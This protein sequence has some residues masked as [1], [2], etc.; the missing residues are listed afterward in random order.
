MQHARQGRQHVFQLVGVDVEAGHQ[1]HVLLAV[2]DAHVTVFLDHRDI[3][4]LQPA[5]GVE[6][7]VGGVLALPVALHHLWS[8]DAQLADRAER[9]FVALVVDDLALGRGHR[10]ADGAQ[11]DVLDRVDRGHRAGFG[12]AETF[13]YRAAGNLGP[14]LGSGQLQGHAA[15]QGDLQRGKVELLE[16]LVVAQGNEQG[17]EADEAA[18]L[19]ARQIL[20]HARQVARVGDQHVMVADQHHGHAMEGEGVDVIERQRRYHDFAAFVHVRRH[21]RPGLQ[22][23]GDQVAVGQHRALGHP[24]GA[25]GVLQHGELAASRIG[26]PDR[27]AAAL[28]QG[29]GELDGLRQ[30]VGRHHLLHVLDH[31]VDQQ[32]LERRQHVADFADDDRLDSGPGNDLLDQMRHV[33]QADQGFGAGVVELVLHFPRGIQRIGVDHHQ[34]GT[35]GAE[36]GD[37]VLQNVGQ[38]HGDAVARLQVGVLL[39]IGG[40]GTGQLI[41]L[42]VADG[43]A[44]VAEGRLVGET[45]A[46]LFQYR[47]NIRV[48]VGIDFGSNPNGILVLPKIFGHA[49]PLLSNS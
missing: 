3:A 37:R 31:T 13:A 48:L 15:G 17:V 29:F 21:H 47:L 36:H 5:I 20:D 27:F 26:V 6:D 44:E 14:T 43:L 38:L 34:P 24:G 9:Q 22:H 32:A 45:L 49:S 18:E 39:Q 11:L 19:V 4:G 12:H 42:A 33:G 2:D 23:V 10:D 41:Q 28:A 35:Q 16:V 40:E 30:V 7:F 1:N 8:L 25:T 46:G